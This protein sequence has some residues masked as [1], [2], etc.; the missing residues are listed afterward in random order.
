MIPVNVPFVRP[1]HMKKVINVI[2]HN[3]TRI[4]N[5]ICIP[6]WNED[7]FGTNPRPGWLLLYDKLDNLG[8]NSWNDPEI[9]FVH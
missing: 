8:Y 7:G 5:T 3:L 6:G 4:F 2:F 1:Y 9:R